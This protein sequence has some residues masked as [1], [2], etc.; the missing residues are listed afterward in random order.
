MRQG[1]LINLLKQF[2]FIYNFIINGQKEREA[3]K[4]PPLAQG[5]TSIFF[6]AT[7]QI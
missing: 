3:E 6:S 5:E 7:R 4:K 1:F 2:F